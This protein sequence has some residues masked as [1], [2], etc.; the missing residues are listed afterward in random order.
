VAP[1][2]I[3]SIE[4]I[5]MSA[6]G[7]SLT[8]GL[9]DVLGLS[10]K[11]NPFNTATGW[12]ATSTGG[13]AG[14][15]TVNVGA[16]VVVDGTSTNDLY[17]NGSWLSIGT[18]QNTVG[19][20][21]KTYKVL[22]DLTNAEAQ[23]IV[24]GNV[25]VHMA[26]TVISTANELAGS[27]NLTEANSTGGTPVRI[28]LANTDAAAG[29]TIQ[30]NWGGQLIT[31]PLSATDIANGYVDMPVTTAQLLAVTP[32]GNSANVNAV[33]TLLN[34][35]TDVAHS[36]GQ[37]IAVNFTVPTTPIID[38]AVWS[39]TNTTSSLAGIPEAY[40]DTLT[41]T[42][43]TT[44]TGLL[45]DNTLYY[46][47]AVATGNLGTVLRV[48]L[49]TVAASAAV[50]TV[51]GDTVTVH[52]GD[53][54]LTGITLSATDITNK[55]VD[56]TVTQAQLESQAFGNVTVSAEV[57]SAA[58][59]NT[60]LTSPLVV[61]W[62][63]DLPLTQLASLSQGFEIDGNVANGKLGISNE[64]Q[65]AQNVGDVNGDGFDDIE[66]TD[67][68]GTRYVVYGGNRLGAVNVSQMSA[69]GNSF[70][71]IITGTGST[72]QPTRGGDINGDGLSDLLIGNG[73]N[74]YIVFGKTT[75][76][77]SVALASL[78]TNGF[79]F[80]STSSINEPSVVGDVN[81]DGYEDILFNNTTNF[82]NYLVFGGT[83]FTP[84]GSVALP[85]GTSGT[86]ATGTG[87]GAS[88]V[89]ISNGGA[90][91]SGG[92]LPTLHGDFNGDGYSDF[93]LAQVP[94]TG[95]GTGPVYVYYGSSSV[96][97]WNSSTLTSPTNGRGFVINGL[98]GQ[99]SIK[100]STTNA[101]DIN[102]DGLDDIAFSDG[103]TT[104]YVMFGKT[105]STSLN[106][107][108]LAAGN[109]GFIIKGG[110]N[111]VNSVVTDTDVIGDFN[112]DG[113]ADF[114]VS[115]TSMSIGGTVVGGAYLI[116]GR[117]AT[118]ALTLDSLNATEGFRIDGVSAATLLGRTASAA[119][120]VNGD[121]FAD[122]VI[123]TYQGEAVGAV[124]SAGITRV[125][126][127]GVTKL[128]PMVFQSANGDAMGTTGADTLTGT[129]GNNQLVAGDGNDTLIGNGGADVLYGGRGDDTIVVNADNVAKMS[130]SGTAQAIARIDG[131]SGID[132]LKL[133]GAGILLDL[134]LVSG[135][136]LQNIEKIDLTGS[137]NNTLKL[138]LTDMLQGFDNSN[139]FNSSNTTSGLAATVSKNQLLVDGDTGDKLVL[140]DL[141]NWTASGTNVV[142]NGHTYVAYNHNTSAQQLLIDNHLLV[143]AT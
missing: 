59:G 84:G 43:P 113:L 81:G 40:Y 124:A 57:T 63:Y 106:V 37:P 19:G 67:L 114:V 117:T 41:A 129:S 103:T 23:V 91:N 45:V 116:Y 31:V 139:V 32:V 104:A 28:S 10:E 110:T 78:G 102:G 138:S 33:V 85:T 80:T 122:L 141:A 61:N 137:G 136:A 29:N 101:G 66:L 142:A 105:N 34:G 25:H 98:T 115:N 108:D 30:L 46:S 24:D 125:I 12:T 52:W 71:F 126:Y 109:G 123:T 58:S 1:A 65:G 70:G 135:P 88:Y 86:L 20:V 132:T 69:A 22:S 99:N 27:L 133:D 9:L 128:E 35:T 111:N 6:S 140:S 73:T 131:G 97:A 49:P 17:L 16:Q 44:T 127:G 53:Q 38:A 7:T 13:A 8:M 11:N 74:S 89:N 47:D 95:I 64:D 42:M 26:P 60:S 112:G 96:A 83:N 55:Y 130:L 3:Q 51:A 92:I 90:Y 82:T 119:G 107:S 120:D 2:A 5:N 79:A 77:G 100:F 15:G 134:S 50:P 48:Q 94:T 62:N 4:R 54:T 39:T 21:T 56:V 143:S 121:G 93:A 75:S 18:V 118:T 87:S 68:S 36:G 14:W 76:I 72:L